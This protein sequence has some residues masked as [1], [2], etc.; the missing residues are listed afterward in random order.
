MQGISDIKELF[1]EGKLDILVTTLGARGSI[2]YVREGDKVIE[3]KIEAIKA[4]KV[5]D[6]SGGGDAYMSG[7]LYGYLKGYSPSDCCRLGTVMASYIIQ[8]EGCLSNVPDEAKLLSEFNSRF[9]KE[10]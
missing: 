4:T 10:M 9:K 2:C 1:K 8:E 6:A 7:F 3:E 5:V